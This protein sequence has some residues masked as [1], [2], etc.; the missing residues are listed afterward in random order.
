L[1]DPALAALHK[2]LT[3]PNTDDHNK[4][5][6]AQVVLDR[7]GFKPGMVVEVQTSKWDQAADEVYTDGGADRSSLLPGDTRALPGGVGNHT[8]EDKAQ[9]AWNAQEDAD[10][11]NAEPE[12]F[13]IYQDENTVRCEVVDPIAPPP[14]LRD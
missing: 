9:L 6:A 8:W 10:R 2:V 7:A 4:V 3:D 11:D 1:V 5:R 13:R 12:V 14:H